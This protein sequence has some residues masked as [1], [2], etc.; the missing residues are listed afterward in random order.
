M[1]HIGKLEGDLCEVAMFD[2]QRTQ[3]GKP[4]QF[5][6]RIKDILWPTAD[7]HLLCRVQNA[8]LGAA[9]E[10]SIKRAPA[11]LVNENL[12]QTLQIVHAAIATDQSTPTEARA[13]ACLSLRCRTPVGAAVIGGDID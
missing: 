6:G 11:I 13:V 4:L 2:G 12:R 10:Y 1:K 5:A 8:K 7:H 9:R 3:L